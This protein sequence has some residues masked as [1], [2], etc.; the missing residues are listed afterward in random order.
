MLTLACCLVF[1]AG[2]AA[3]TPGDADENL[4]QRKRQALQLLWAARAEN[5]SVIST[6]MQDEVETALDKAAGKKLTDLLKALDPLA[7]KSAEACQQ[8]VTWWKAH[9]DDYPGEQTAEPQQAAAVPESKELQARKAKVQQYLSEAFTAGLIKAA[10]L[11]E[12]KKAIQTTKGDTL[13]ELLDMLETISGAQQ[14]VVDQFLIWWQDKRREYLGAA[15]S[16]PRTAPA[17]AAREPAPPATPA[18]EPVA[19]DDATQKRAVDLLFGARR[20]FGDVLSGAVVDQVE[21]ALK[22]YTA[23]KKAELL[24]EIEL[25]ADRKRATAKKFALWWKE[26]SAALAARSPTGTKGI[27]AAPPVE[28]PALG[29]ATTE[30]TAFAY[31]Q[32]GNER[33]LPASRDLIV[34]IKANR[35]PGRL[36]P[37]DWSVV[38]YDSTASFKAVEIKFSGGTLMKLSKPGRVLEAFGNNKPFARDALRVDSDQALKLALAA[39]PN[40]VNV[41]SC[42]FRLTRGEGGLPVWKLRLWAAKLRH[43][44]EEGELGELILSATD[45]TILRNDL[46]PQRLD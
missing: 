20:E 3:Q 44:L 18:P 5:R 26:E 40:G 35:S 16:E 1:A 24:Q 39:V 31:V 33:V 22:S 2:L 29:A 8:F 41:K 45:G 4:P 21:E 10:E 6:A 46:K 13:A 42:S 14:R 19:V 12:I 17:P 36:V 34:E 28:A 30:P 37:R 38:Y 32:A 27:A 43:P 11:S 15:A 25:L 7:S 9:K 23:D